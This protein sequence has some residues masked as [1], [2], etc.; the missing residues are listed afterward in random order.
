MEN[1]FVK[2]TGDKKSGGT[3]DSWGRRTRALS[4]NNLD[5]LKWRSGKKDKGAK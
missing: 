2:L 1:T 3:A 5:R 4:S